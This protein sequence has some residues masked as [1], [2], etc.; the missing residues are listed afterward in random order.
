M[1]LPK[2]S[3]TRSRWKEQLSMHP[4]LWFPFSFFFKTYLSLSLFFKWKKCIAFFSY[5][6]VEEE[7]IT[8]EEKVE[9]CNVTRNSINQGTEDPTS[10]S[11]SLKATYAPF[12]YKWSQ[13]SE[14]LLAISKLE[15]GG[16]YHLLLQ[17]TIL[18]KHL[19]TSMEQKCSLN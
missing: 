18:L 11:E 4:N 17:A 19:G 9:Q 14:E 12:A 6:L 15:L 13:V 10:F 7:E 2:G 1:N 16:S 3:K 8:N 5:W